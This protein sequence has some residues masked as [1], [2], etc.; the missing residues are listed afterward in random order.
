MSSATIEPPLETK[1]IA[2]HVL[3]VA[4]L[5]V[6]VLVVTAT[7]LDAS[8]LHL[9][10]FDRTLNDQVGYVSVARNFLETGEMRSNVVYPSILG[11]GTVRTTSTCRGTI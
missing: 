2:L 6:V 4:G 1:K 7:W 5:A 11:Q 10:G 8:R 3:A 9:N